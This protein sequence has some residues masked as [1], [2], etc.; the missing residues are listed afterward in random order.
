MQVI[1]RIISATF[2]ATICISLCFGNYLF[3]QDNIDNKIILL[4]DHFPPLSYQN[5]KGE[6]IG[7]ADKI[8][9]KLFKNANLHYQIKSYPWKRA[10]QM[11]SKQE[12][13][14][15]YPL[16]RTENR[17]D[18]YV[19]IT[20]LFSLKI[21]TY[22]LTKPNATFD[23]T[24]GNHQFACIKTTINCLAVNSLKIPESALSEISNIST[25]Q[26]VKMVA[27]KRVDFIMMTEIEF[28]YAI[29]ILNL[30]R[31]TFT[32][33]EKYNYV[34]TDYLAASKGFDQDIIEKIK[35]AVTN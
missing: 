28:E 7:T 26:L 31:K 1:I 25:V 19:W 27:K 29:K 6:F 22:G 15:I 4:T 23:I 35:A 32:K 16:S 12:D 13:V 33:I 10:L 17:E 11:V 9:H 8:I 34:A 2:I 20:P 21:K 30:D 24:K 14:L 18:D 5:E 3:A